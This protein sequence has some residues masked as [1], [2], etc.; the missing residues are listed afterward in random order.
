MKTRRK[1]KQA[2]GVGEA[3]IHEEKIVGLSGGGR[4]RLG[5]SPVQE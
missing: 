1:R 2:P 4:L 3:G 5:L